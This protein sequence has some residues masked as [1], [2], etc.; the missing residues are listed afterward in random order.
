MLNIGYSSFVIQGQYPENVN[1][2]TSCPC[3]NSVTVFHTLDLCFALLWFEGPHHAKAG[4]E[5]FLILF[6]T[7]AVLGLAI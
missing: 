2:I 6:V 7:L 5:F 4:L 1:Q 3:W